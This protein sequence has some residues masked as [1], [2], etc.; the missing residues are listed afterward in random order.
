MTSN[1][2]FSADTSPH[3]IVGEEAQRLV[4]AALEGAPAGTVPLVVGDLNTNLDF[5]QDR[6]EEILSA[7]M[8]ERGMC[9]ASTYF[10]PRRTRGTRERWT[11]RQRR[12]IVGTGQKQ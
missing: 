5:P 1:G 6:Q 2:S 10:R 4:M 9:C 12:G 11:W 3:Q 8:R 7:T